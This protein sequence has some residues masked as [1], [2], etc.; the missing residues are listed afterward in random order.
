[1]NKGQE[2]RI[3]DV[4]SPIGLKTLNDTLNFILN[5]IRQRIDLT[6]RYK[7]VFFS[8]SVSVP[9]GGV[10]TLNFGQTFVEEPQIVASAQNG[11]SVRL[12][13]P[14]GETDMRKKVN[15]SFSD[16]AISGIVSVIA[17]GKADI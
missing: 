12:E 9:A 16:P 15:I 5:T 17:I 7:T 13:I 3:T 6:E 14:T 10:N 8:Q 4:T 1:M 2:V 11:A